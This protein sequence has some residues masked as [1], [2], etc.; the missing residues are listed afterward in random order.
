MQASIPFAIPFENG[1]LTP[2]N[3]HAVF[4][5]FGLYF[6]VDLTWAF[7]KVVSVEVSNSPI[8]DEN[9]PNIA[10]LASLNLPDDW[11][12]NLPLALPGREM[13]ELIGRGDIQRAGELM[14]AFVKS[15]KSDDVMGALEEVQFGFG[16]EE[17]EPAAAE[18]LA[19]QLTKWREAQEAEF[20]R[21]A[22]AAR[23]AARKADAARRIC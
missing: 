12:S 13:V 21:V 11:A 8:A 23:R 10:N 4:V 19:A 20:K 16:F 14:T 5:K 15:I 17:F 22:R 2:Q 9:D 18:T 7:N 6:D 1:M 3:G